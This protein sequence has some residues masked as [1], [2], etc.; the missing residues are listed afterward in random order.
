MNTPVAQAVGGSGAASIAGM[1]FSLLL[2]I[3]LIF[4]LAWLIRRVQ[5]LRG[6]RRGSLQLV[7]GLSVGPKERVVLV[8]LGEQQ[9]LLGVAAGS[10]NLLQRL[11]APLAPVETETQV[12]GTGAFAERLREMLG[13]KS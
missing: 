3:A 6:L 1:F 10:V 9:Y 12:P 8:Q 11:D 7:G 13:Q 2:V 4:A 5:N